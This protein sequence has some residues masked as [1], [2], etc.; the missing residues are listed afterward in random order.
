MSSL[1]TLA[2]A[3]I[4]L[5]ILTLGI[6]FA[7]RGLP[8]RRGASIVTTVGLSALFNPLALPF[9]FGTSRRSWRG[10]LGGFALF[11]LCLIAT[12]DAARALAEMSRRWPFE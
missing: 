8:R 2:G 12:C 1:V 10:A 3:W 4:A 6:V 5:Q 9:Y 11:L 7:D